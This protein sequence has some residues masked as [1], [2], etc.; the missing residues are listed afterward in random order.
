MI[1]RIF[2]R[3]ILPSFLTL[4]LQVIISPVSAETVSKTD[5]VAKHFASP[6]EAAKNLIEAAQD[7][8]SSKI[9]A[10]FGP[11]HAEILSSGDDIEDK[12]N[13]EKF[14]ALAKEKSSIQNQGEDRAIL[15]FGQTDWAFPIPVVKTGDQWVFDTKLGMQEILDRRIGRNELSTMGVMKGYVEAQFDYASVD[16]DGDEVAEYALKLRSEPGKFDGLFWEA[17]PGQPESPLGPLFAQAKAEGYLTKKSPDEPPTPYHGYYFKILASQGSNAP[18]GKY[19]YVINGNMIAGFALVAFPA[20]YGSSGIMTF[21][22][23]HQGK[24]YQKN[25][26]PKTNEIAPAL[27]RYDPDSSWELV[28]AKTTP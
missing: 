23:N 1:T 20:K 21:M 18:G 3:R 17:E 25:L 12:N 8:D 14:L 7:G 6:E 15:Q 27:K 26:G 22:V 10:L 9:S 28:D 11:N 16:R 19:D 24:L 5:D 13:R 4:A 2:Y